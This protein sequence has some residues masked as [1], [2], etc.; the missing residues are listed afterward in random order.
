MTMCEARSIQPGFHS[1]ELVAV[2]EVGE[3][4]KVFCLGFI[5]AKFYPEPT[6]KK[7][8]VKYISLNCLNFKSMATP[9]IL[10]QIQL[11]ARMDY[12]SL[13]NFLVFFKTTIHLRI[14]TAT[15]VSP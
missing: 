5:L 7:K 13:N 14:I 6:V 15:K 3:R 1:S 2:L 9:L 10:Q 11:L 8:I 4:G 12:H